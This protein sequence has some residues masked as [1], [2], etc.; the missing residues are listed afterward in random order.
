MG[1]GF[2]GLFF[3]AAAGMIACS[4]AAATPLSP[5]EAAKKARIKERT[6]HKVP[7]PVQGPPEKFVEPPKDKIPELW[8]P[9]GEKLI[10]G[11]RWGLV[12]VGQAV[13]W[14]EWVEENGRWLIAIRLRT[15][16]NKVLS[17]MYPVDDFVESIVDPVTF[18]PLRFVKKINEGGTHVDQLTQFD[19]AARKAVW[20]SP[21]GPRATSGGAAFW[22]FR[23]RFPSR[24]RA[25]GEHRREAH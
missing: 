3:V 9:V 16:T 5:E 18:L 2:R 7:L 17:A 11:I 20:E 22:W 12:P 8:F 23:K 25:S 6:S 13:A 1:M 19:H 24:I 15:K 10:F 14:T 4:A 21:R